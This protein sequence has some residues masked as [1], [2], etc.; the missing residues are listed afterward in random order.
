MAS[1]RSSFLFL[2]LFAV[3]C[4]AQGSIEG[5]DDYWT[6]RAEEA[7]EAALKAFNPNPEEVTAHFNA[8]VSA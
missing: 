1:N 3:S 6:K 8:N 5:F 4:I 7:K 2:T